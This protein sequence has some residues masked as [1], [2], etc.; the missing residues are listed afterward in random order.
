MIQAFEMLDKSGISL[1]VFG[2]PLEIDL[3]KLDT[4]NIKYRGV[5]LF[6]EI[7]TILKNY[8]VLILPSV[9]YEMMRLVIQEAITAGLYV[10]GTDVPGLQKY[11]NR[12]LMVS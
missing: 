12:E 2:P 5:F 6:D 11:F 8:D 1:S 3:E 7:S 9:A 4:S 10:I